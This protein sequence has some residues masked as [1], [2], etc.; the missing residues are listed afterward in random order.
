MY[1]SFKMPYQQTNYRIFLCQTKIIERA[2]DLQTTRRNTLQ[3]YR[4]NKQRWTGMDR[5]RHRKCNRVTTN[6]F[7]ARHTLRLIKIANGGP[8]RPFENNRSS[9]RCLSRL[10]PARANE[11]SEWKSAVSSSNAAKP[12]ALNRL[13]GSVAD[14]HRRQF[15]CHPLAFDF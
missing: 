4:S 5:G 10:R 12:S 7:K 2:N 8:R 13:S 9:F 14:P 3:T 1:N 11:P 6:L 15:I